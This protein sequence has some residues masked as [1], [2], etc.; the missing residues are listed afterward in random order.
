MSIG[1]RKGMPLLTETGILYG[2]L[3]VLF[4]I[5]FPMSIS[6][7]VKSLLKDVFKIEN[8]HSDKESLDIEYY[9][10]MDEIE[11]E[12]ESGVQCVHQ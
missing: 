6:R 11:E 4:K 5:Q 7:E 3:L 10:K 8:L 9:K 1:R 2:D 12:Q